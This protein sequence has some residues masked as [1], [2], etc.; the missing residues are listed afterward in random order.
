MFK[1]LHHDKLRTRLNKTNTH[2]HVT[3][4]DV[5][6]KKENFEKDQFAN[7]LPLPFVRSPY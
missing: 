1:T 3:A 5:F 6:V 2:V 7:I 4:E